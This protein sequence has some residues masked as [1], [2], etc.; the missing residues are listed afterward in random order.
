MIQI[1][2]NGKFVKNI[3]FTSEPSQACY[4]DWINPNDFSY[5]NTQGKEIYYEYDGE[6]DNGNLLIYFKLRDKN[7]QTIVNE[8]Y[9]TKFPDIS[10]EEYGTDKNYFSISFDSSNNYY[11]FRDN[12]PYANTQHG[13]VFK[14]RET[15]CNYKYYLRYDGK[16]G[17]SPL[18]EANSYFTILS[19]QININNE[20]YVDV[21]YKDQN[22][23]LLG[24]QEEK[25]QEAKSK[26]VVTGITGEGVQV[27]L[28]YDSTTS[29]Y[30]LRY[31]AQFTTSG[32]YTITVKYDNSY[33][34]KFETTNKLT[35]IDNI[36]PL[37]QE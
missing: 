8:N 4:L 29:N 31:K 18:S 14:M 28:A 7:N 30:A 13:W 16:K 11:I 34:L 17:G 27:N 37:I 5:K 35:V 10:S 24:L 1:E 6:F 26:T 2:I 12:V 36:Y 15:T 23:Q 25:L 19:T 22:N 20:G 3:T 21:I 9:F 32:V 33:D